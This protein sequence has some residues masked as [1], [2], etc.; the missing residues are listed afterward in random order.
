MTEMLMLKRTLPYANA[1]RLHP[2]PI[3]V[4]APASPPALSRIVQKSDMGADIVSRISA[5]SAN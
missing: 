2:S 1:E 3:A 4:A 5:N